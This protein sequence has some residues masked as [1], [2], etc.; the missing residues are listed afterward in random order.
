[1]L[2]KIA[3]ITAMAPGFNTGMMT[4]DLA[5][6]SLINRYFED[7]HIQLF[8]AERA[9]I[10]PFNDKKRFDYKLLNNIND[11]KDYDAILVWG[12]FLTSHRYHQQD[13]QNRLKKLGDAY[14]E[15]MLDRIASIFL[16]NQASDDLLKKT[17]CIGG[18]IYI[19]NTFDDLNEVYISSIQRLYSGANLVLKRDPISAC[20]AQR[21]SQRQDSLLG[22]DCAFF[23]DGS[24]FGVSKVKQVDK[25]L[26]IGYSFGR[27]VAKNEELSLIIENILS[28]LEIKFSSKL[29]NINWLKQNQKQ[30][31]QDVINKINNIKKC[32]LIITDTYHLCVN[33]W[34]EGVPALCIGEGSSLTHGTLSDKKKEILYTMFNIRYFYV[35]T[36][37]LNNERGLRDIEEKVR[38]IL[39]HKDVISRIFTKIK[40]QV[41]FAQ[42]RLI[43]SLNKVLYDK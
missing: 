40:S 7:V 37:F 14:D 3:V 11:L 8:N 28:R 15:S 5:V 42:S 26:C 9:Y 25:S 32:D 36:E 31:L 2:K 12:D 16:F 17:L 20:F 27:T 34:R 1:M 39:E 29:L 43:L 41:D 18:S 33:A 21:Y 30:P 4:V 23:F 6:E 13:I 10:I 35:F 24:N 38:Y 19:N 22:V